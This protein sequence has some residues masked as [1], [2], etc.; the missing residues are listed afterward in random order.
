MGHC[1]S[2]EEFPDPTHPELICLWALEV[3]S[4]HS[5]AVTCPQGPSGGWVEA[6]PSEKP[7]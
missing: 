7:S 6:I 5:H 3:S 4:G 2:Q 1:C